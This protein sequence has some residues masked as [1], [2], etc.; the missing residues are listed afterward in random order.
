MVSGSYYGMMEEQRICKKNGKH[1]KLLWWVGTLWPPQSLNTVTLKLDP[2]PGSD[3]DSDSEEEDQADMDE[4]EDEYGE[5]SK[6]GK[7]RS[8]G[9]GVGNS[10]KRRRIDREVRVWHSR[11]ITF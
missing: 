7:R 5:A 6:S 10:G 1:G 11:E 8:L 3:E 2:D 9:E 4:D